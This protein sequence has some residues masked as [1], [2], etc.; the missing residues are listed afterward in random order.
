VVAWLAKWNRRTLV[1]Q[2]CSREQLEQEVIA[3]AT[4]LSSLLDGGAQYINWLRGI[5]TAAAGAPMPLVATHNDLTMWNIVIDKRGRLGVLDWESARA[6]DLPLK[7]FFYAMVDAVLAT[8]AYTDRLAAFQACFAQDG[9]YRP[10]IARLQRRFTYT[11]NMPVPVMELCFH[12][13]WIQH[14]VNEHGV[15]HPGEQRSFFRIVQ[16]LAS[17]PSAAQGSF[18]P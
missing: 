10:W 1:I 4:L 12:A 2:S 3:P 13:C 16:W 15:G 11:R 9:T 17:R 7:D 18:V 5:C 6:T 14:A 8:G